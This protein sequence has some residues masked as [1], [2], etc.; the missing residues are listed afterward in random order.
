MQ[1]QD[2]AVI[3]NKVAEARQSCNQEQSCRSKTKLYSGT[4]LQKQDRAV[5]RNKVAEA[6]KSCIQEQSCR[7]KAQNR[8]GGGRKIHLESTRDPKKQASSCQ[9]RKNQTSNPDSRQIKNEINVLSTQGVKFFCT[10]ANQFVNKRDDLLMFIQKDEPDILLITE[11]IPKSQVNPITN[12]LL[13]VDGYE[14]YLYF[15]CIDSNLGRAGIRGL[16]IYYKE[17]MSVEEV[18]VSVND[19]RDHVWVEIPTDKNGVL[20]C[21]CVYR[22]QSNDTNI[23]RCI[24]STKGI[25]QLIRTAYH[26]NPDL[27][28]GRLIV[29]GHRLEK[30][31]CA[32][33]TAPC[34]TL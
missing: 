17:T 21:G 31:T 25:S 11:V 23:N 27:L 32:S 2:R 1:K 5:F 15:N 29:E 19:W 13:K 3:R 10:N 22:S 4:K 24:Q 20:L 28:S 34:P 26:R 12:A 14:Y 7:S 16:A 9:V 33:G 18:K 8:D 30:R 6:R